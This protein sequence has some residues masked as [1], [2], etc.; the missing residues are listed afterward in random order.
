MFVE[1]KPAPAP[2]V[3]GGPGGGT[4]VGPL[5][6][7]DEILRDRARKEAAEKAKQAQVKPDVVSTTVAP[8]AVN[9]FGNSG[10]AIRPYGSDA[11]QYNKDATEAGLQSFYKNLYEQYVPKVAREVGID[12]EKKRRDALEKK[13]FGA[14]GVDLNNKSIEGYDASGASYYNDKLYERKRVE[15]ATGGFVPGSG[16]GDTVPAMLT[17]GE[18]V[19]NKSAVDK[20]GLATLHKA[21][22][23]KFANGGSVRG[24]NNS[25]SGFNPVLNS[26]DFSKSILRFEASLSVLQT[27]FNAF[28]S[29]ANALAQAM[30]KFPSSLTGTFSH[31]VNVNI[32]GAEALAV[33]S[34][35]LEKI[36]VEKAKQVL[37]KYVKNNFPEAGIVE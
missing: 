31:T 19:L 25:G 22:A 1:S 8:G 28:N 32:S 26:E 6:D 3:I 13:N 34:P 29:S 5:S 18:F 4:V 21:N 23:Q 7:A 35:E 33:L 17:P 37:S 12:E 9:S 2:V 20:I 16:Y 36:A 10:T 27:A 15:Y 30:N 24:G 11:E 14:V